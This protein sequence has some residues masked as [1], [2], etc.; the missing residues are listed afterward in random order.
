MKLVENKKL[1]KVE[2]SA[3]SAIVAGPV[4]VKKISASQKRVNYCVV[5]ARK[6]IIKKWCLKNVDTVI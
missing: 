2:R 4:S 1:T 5:T 3:F 6:K